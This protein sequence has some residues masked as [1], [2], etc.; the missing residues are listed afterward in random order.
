MRNKTNNARDQV[1]FNNLY[2]S[3]DR[4]SQC[5][6]VPFKKHDIHESHYSGV[7]FKKM[8]YAKGTIVAFQKI[9]CAKTT[10]VAFSS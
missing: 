6:D 4:V 9:I 3:K 8:I 5:T 10:I 1:Q 2:I 7:P